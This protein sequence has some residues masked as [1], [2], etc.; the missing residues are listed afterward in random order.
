MLLI[1]DMLN[2]FLDRWSDDDRADLVRGIQSLANIFR[3]EG[4]PVAWVRQEFK[5]DLADHEPRS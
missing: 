5:A 1:I 2:D 4:Y 3:S